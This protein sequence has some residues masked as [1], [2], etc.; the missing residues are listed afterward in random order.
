MTMGRGFVRFEGTV[1]EARRRLTD[2][3]GVEVFEKRPRGN[4]YV[5]ACRDGTLYVRA[6]HIA[7]ILRA[8]GIP[9]PWTRTG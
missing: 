3:A 1:E 8:L 7:P 4:H 2:E 9:S 6:K 5:V